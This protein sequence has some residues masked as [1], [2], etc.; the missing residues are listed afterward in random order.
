MSTLL[1]DELNGPFQD[2]KPDLDLGDAYT[3]IGPEKGSDAKEKGIVAAQESIQR[4]LD[5][6]T[7]IVSLLTKG[8]PFASVWVQQACHAKRRG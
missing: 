7:F 3:M 5:C 2:T 4:A 8:T 6:Q 1:I